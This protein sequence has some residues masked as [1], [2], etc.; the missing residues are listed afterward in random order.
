MGSGDVGGA[1]ALAA[2]QRSLIQGPSHLTIIRSVPFSSVGF[3]SSRLSLT[4]LVGT[5]ESLPGVEDLPDLP[6][7]DICHPIIYR[8]RHSFDRR[9]GS[10]A[11]KKKKKKKTL[12]N[13]TPNVLIDE[14]VRVI[15]HFEMNQPEFPLMDSGTGSQQSLRTGVDPTARTCNCFHSLKREDRMLFQSRGRPFHST[16]GAPLLYAKHIPNA[17]LHRQSQTSSGSLIAAFG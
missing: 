11:P 3:G 4:V 15:I 8:T 5:D 12:L 17:F 16:L 10:R 13:L 9:R 1:G 14:D 2:W 6:G 7:Q